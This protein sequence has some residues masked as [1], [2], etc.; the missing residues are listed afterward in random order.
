[1]IQ[2]DVVEAGENIDGMPNSSEKLSLIEG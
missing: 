1:L 2:N